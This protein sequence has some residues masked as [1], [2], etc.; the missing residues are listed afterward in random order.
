M[1]SPPSF[2]AP[3]SNLLETLAPESIDTIP[4]LSALL[5]RLQQNPS[6]NS[7]LATSPPVATPSV[8]LSDKDREGKDKGPITTKDIP[9]ATDSLKHGL[10]KARALVKE[11]PDMH[12]TVEEQEEDIRELEAK[13]KA[14]RKVL[15][16]LRNV[17][18]EV[19][20]ERTS[21]MET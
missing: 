18:L 19:K 15:M 4:I 10:Q 13:I 9:A 12:R 8:N 16:D 21:R 11:L 20:R 17:G 7:I 14:Q 3:Q 6:P 1:A 2:S 5:A